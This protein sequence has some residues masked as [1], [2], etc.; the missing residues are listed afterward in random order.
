MVHG[1]FEIHARRRRGSG[2]Q[3]HERCASTANVQNTPRVEID[4][5]CLVDTACS[6]L[7]TQLSGVWAETNA[8]HNR[9]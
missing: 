4:G 7:Q 3:Q 8:L 6:L 2:Y 9:P 1:E 5:R